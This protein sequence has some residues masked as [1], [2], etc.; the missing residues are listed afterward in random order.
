MVYQVCY[1]SF[2]QSKNKAFVDFSFCMG[3]VDLISVTPSAKN[4]NQTGKRKWA[5]E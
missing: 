4:I 3:F 1:S 5:F 2:K